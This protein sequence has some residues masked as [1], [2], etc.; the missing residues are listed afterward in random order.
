MP[1]RVSAGG[2]GTVVDV[3]ECSVESEWD[4]DGYHESLILRGRTAE[5]SFE[6]AGRVVSLIPLRNRRKRDDG[7][8][9]HTRIAEGMTKYTY[10]G[11]KALGMSEYLDQIVDGEPLGR[12]QGV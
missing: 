12:R 11:R 8:L 5:E 9:L 3:E 4:D 10:N 1:T 6:L 2:A 7:N